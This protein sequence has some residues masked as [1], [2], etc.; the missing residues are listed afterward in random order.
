MNRVSHNTPVPC[1]RPQYLSGGTLCSLKTQISY[2]ETRRRKTVSRLLVWGP[3]LE[4]PPS[5]W[6]NTS[7]EV[8]SLASLLCIHR[9][10][11][12]VRHLNKSHRCNHLACNHFRNYLFAYVLNACNFS[13]SIPRSRRGNQPNLGSEWQHWFALRSA[14]GGME[15]WQKKK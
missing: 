7:V 12:L 4:A 13:G 14:K 8:K 9:A 6:F 5:H 11:T 10:A 2:D 1:S 3:D 15:N